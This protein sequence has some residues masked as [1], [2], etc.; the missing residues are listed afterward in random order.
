MDIEEYDMPL[1]NSNFMGFDNLV[2]FFGAVEDRNDPLRIGRVKIR[3]FGVHP[4][5]KDIVTTDDLP[6]AMPIQPITSAGHAGIGYAPLGVVVGSIVFGFFLDGIDAQLPFFTGV[7]SGGLGHLT[8][9]M[10]SNPNSVITGPT[11]LVTDLANLVASYDSPRDYGKMGVGN[12]APYTGPNEFTE[13][14]KYFAPRLMNAFTLSAEQAAGILGNLAE[15]SYGL[16]PNVIQAVRGENIRGVKTGPPESVQGNLGYG[17]AQ[18][19]QA[20]RNALISTAQASNYNTQSDIA[21]YTYLVHE[22]QG[23]FSSS[24]SQLKSTTS[25]KDATQSFMNNYLKP[26][27]PNFNSRENWANR[28]YAAITT[29]NVPLRSSGTVNDPTVSSV[30]K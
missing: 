2:W 24:I 6:W 21:N 17:W 27:K 7:I 20:R 3:V 12:T 1:L 15:E 5:N 14:V 11:Q 4:M 9:S 13:K 18:W 23:S 29:I 16:I 25:V 26:G 10:T 28:A 8:S 30:Q 22:L 19:D